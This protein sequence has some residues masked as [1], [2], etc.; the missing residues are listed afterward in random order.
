M[1]LD[2]NMELSLVAVNKMEWSLVVVDKNG[3]VTGSGK[4]I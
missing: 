1:V 4:I 3:V 2:N